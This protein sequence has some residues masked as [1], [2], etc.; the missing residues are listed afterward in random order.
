MKMEFQFVSSSSNKFR[1]NWATKS[2][3]IQFKK[4]F[5]IEPIFLPHR[6]I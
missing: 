1:K 4:E 6:F 3:Y 2:T 5:G